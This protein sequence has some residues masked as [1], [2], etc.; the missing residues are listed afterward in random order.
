MFPETR[1]GVDL[2]VLIVQ[3]PSGV[4]GEDAISD[5]VMT[6]SEDGT[7]QGGRAP[8]LRRL[9]HRPPGVRQPGMALPAREFRR[10][11]S[12]WVRDEARSSAALVSGL[13]RRP[14]AVLV[15][16]ACLGAPCCGGRAYAH[17]AQPLPYPL[18][19][20]LRSVVGAQVG[21]RA[22]STKSCTSRSSTSSLVMCRPRQ[23]P[24]TPGSTHQ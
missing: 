3:K 4:K 19:D 12:H 13:G 2:V 7:D 9:P 11:L 6:Q 5:Q 24:G 18:G 23:S 1:F 15:G 17:L 22:R 21:R 14:S 8:A 16:R 10:Q 20:E